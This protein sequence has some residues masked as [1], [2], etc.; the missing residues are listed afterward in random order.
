MAASQQ[1]A[2]MAHARGRADPERDEGEGWEEGFATASKV[3]RP[4]EPFEPK[5]VEEEISQWQDWRLTF[6]SW[7]VF[8]EDA[9]RKEIEAIEG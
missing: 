9:Y 6:K 8:A 2:A 3:M 4:P 1:S 7:I 5:S